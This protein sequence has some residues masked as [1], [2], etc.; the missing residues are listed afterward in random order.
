MDNKFRKLFAV[1]KPIIGMIHLA[2]DDLEEKIFRAINELQIYQ[3][4]GVNGAII[5][6]YHATGIEL[7]NALELI[8]KKKWEIK[9]G[10]NYLKN[11][12]SSF[13]LAHDYGASFIQLDGVQGVCDKY[14][15]N[16]AR[17]P[18][19][20]VFGGV[21]FKYQPLTGRTLDEDIEQGKSRCDAIVTT[22]EGTGIETPFEKLRQFKGLLRDFP[23]VVGAGVTL[24]N[25]Y[26]QLQIADGAIIGSYFKP[27]GN[28][29]F[30]I[31]RLKVRNLM[32]IAKQIRKAG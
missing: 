21:R 14:A 8:H 20:L 3:E 11:P 1:E 27:E 30:P 22:G 31:D 18:N 26:E 16:K 9:L 7:V 24:L 10:I 17:F 15:E 32:D 19:L 2:G 5:E 28:T 23:L 29:H 12:S 13:G 6:D 4:E 25:V